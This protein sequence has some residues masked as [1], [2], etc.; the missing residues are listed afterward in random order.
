MTV[1]RQTLEEW[2]SQH[3]LSALVRGHFYIPYDMEIDI[4]RIVAAYEGS[5]ARAP[6]TAIVIKAAAL[7]ARAHPEINRAV[8]ST[9]IGARVVQFEDVHVNVPVLSTHEGK[10]H[11]SATV[12]K[13]ADRMGVQEVVDHLK[14]A[15]ARPLQNLPIGRKFIKNENTLRHRLELRM[16]HALAYGVPALY[17][18][19]GGG[20]SVSSL[21]RPQQKG[22]LLR[23]P[24]FGPTAI[25]LCPGAVRTARGRST[26]FLGVGYDHFALTGAQSIRALEHLGQILVEGKLSELGPTQQ[27]QVGSAQI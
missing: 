17:E 2:F 7:A 6:L 8:L 20:I 9:P 13:H 5:G 16:R 24:S 27:S 26:L 4:T 23:V 15:K 11:L 25:S 21:I 19:F 22:V 3:Q 10:E 1:R 12:I 14:Q 18:K